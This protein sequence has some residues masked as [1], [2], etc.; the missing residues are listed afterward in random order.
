MGHKV[1]FN[2]V[3]KL[4]PE[5]GLEEKVL[6]EGVIFNFTK[7]EHR[8]Y[9]VGVPIDL[10]NKDWEALARI[11]VLEFT[12]KE[13]KTTGKYKVLRIYSGE[14]KESITNYWKKDLEY[15]KQTGTISS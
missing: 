7:N 12:N 8:V 15:L 3:L 2:W 6:R 14:E 1:E 5:N 9:P 10:L 13:N 4:K 11:I